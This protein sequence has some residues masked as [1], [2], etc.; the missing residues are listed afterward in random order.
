MEPLTASSVVPSALALGTHDPVWLDRELYPFTSR[1]F[2]TGAG[3]QHYVD[4]GKGRPILFVH[5]TPS[6]SFEWR[7]AIAALLG[8]HRAIA[9]DHLGF[10]LSDKPLLAA[11]KPTDH[12]ARLLEFVR[13]LDLRELTLVLH[14]FGG[15]IGLPVL[16]EEPERVRSLV[17]VNSW[18]WPHGDDRNV[19]RLSRLVASPLGRFLYRWLNASPR[20]LVP[21]TFARRERLTSAIHRQY[22]GP[23]ANRSERVAP[24]VLGCELAGSDPYYNALWAQRA[25]LSRVPTTL[26]WGLRDPAFGSSYLERWRAALPDAHFVELPDAGHFPQ[27]EAPERVSEAVARAASAESTADDG[28]RR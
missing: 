13:A 3:R 23:F 21:A 26:V 27:E 25:L 14:D 12:A 10:G 19:R 24:W 6:W 4:E 8:E 5:G 22:L 17:I 7:H 9:I 16:F 11:Y 1:Y 18:A 28:A 2:S 20:W 15:P